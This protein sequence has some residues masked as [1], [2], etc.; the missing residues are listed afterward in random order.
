M[1]ASEIFIGMLHYLPSSVHEFSIDG[2]KLHR[3]FYELKRIYPS[4]FKEFKFDTR[5]YWPYSETLDCLID[6]LIITGTLWYKGIGGN[7]YEF[8]REH[9]SAAYYKIE[10]SL[11]RGR[12]SELK[13]MSQIFAQMMAVCK[14]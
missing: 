9:V 5:D 1:E 12:V 8:S 10:P 7:K 3:C 13:T 2:V 6:G 14:Q 4:N 11:S